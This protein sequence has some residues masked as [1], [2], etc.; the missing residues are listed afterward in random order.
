[1]SKRHA[2]ACCDANAM[3]GFVLATKVVTDPRDQFVYGEAWQYTIVDAVG[4][5][6][7]FDTDK[8]KL[9]GAHLPGVP[10]VSVDAWQSTSESERELQRAI[11]KTQAALNAMRSK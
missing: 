2:P 11:Y 4:V 9:C 5:A 3:R 10:H 8:C 6:Q 7:V 1:M